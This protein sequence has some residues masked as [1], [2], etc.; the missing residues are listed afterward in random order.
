MGRGLRRTRTHTSTGS[1]TESEH[2][3]TSWQAHRREQGG[4]H[5]GPE[6]TVN[7]RTAYRC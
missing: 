3:S 7:D 6:N 5:N 2:R 4:F 1:M